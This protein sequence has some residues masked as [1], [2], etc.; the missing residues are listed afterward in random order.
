MMCARVLLV[1]SVVSL[2]TATGA[3]AADAHYTLDAAKS[4]LEYQFTQAGALNKGK[5]TKYTVTL[6]VAGDTPSKLDVVVD[7]ASLDT[8]DKER[9]D[10]LKSADLF[11]V[12]RFP[13]SRFTST[14]ITRT[15]NGYDAVGKMTIRGAAKDVHVPFTFRPA[16]GSLMGKMTI[17][18]LD[19][20]VGQ[21]D[22][23]ATDQVGNDVAVTYAL[24]LVAGAH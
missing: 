6:D 17:K 1:S 11:S 22:W 8:G 10:T 9:D 16:D 24:K 18:R 13:Q 2:L 7:M 12:A 3:A 15:A 4:T 19:F 5:F 14:Q 21:G 20:G 23:K